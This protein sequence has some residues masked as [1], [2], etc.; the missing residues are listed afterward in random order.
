MHILFL[1]KRY[2]GTLYLRK[3]DRSTVILPSGQSPCFFAD[4]GP[5]Q[6]LIAKERNVMKKN[7]LVSLGENFWEHVHGTW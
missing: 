3:D 1:P 6:E 7:C 4:L 5:Q 2:A